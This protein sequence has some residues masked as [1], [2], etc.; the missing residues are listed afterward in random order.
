MREANGALQP[1]MFVQIM[2]RQIH[3]SGLTAPAQG[4]SMRGTLAPGDCLRVR[5]LPL[6]EL[7]AGD[8]VAFR[9]GGRV[10]AHRVVA[11][12]DGH[13]WTQG[14]GNWRRD[15]EPLAP[16]EF[17]GRVEEA[18]GPLGRRPVVGGARGLRR[19]R[20]RHVVAF[21]RWGVLSVAAPFYR[22]LR[23]SRI[24]SCL[25]RPE[26]QVAQFAATGGIQTKFIH[27]GQTIA[28]WQRQTRVWTC[29]APYDLILFPPTS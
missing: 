13:G 27:R 12:Q 6:G 10:W 2:D 1:E 24:V 15:A 25:W 16:E 28:C 4:V 17:I 14:D 20:A 21:V 9:R 3:Y 8:V 7:Q 29:Q 23:A 5:A 11:L 22:V 18:D 19:A 26:V